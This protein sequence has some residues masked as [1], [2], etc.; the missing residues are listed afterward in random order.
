MEYICMFK[1]CFG[2]LAQEIQ[3]GRT[4]N[5]QKFPNIYEDPSD[6]VQPCF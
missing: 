4:H 1:Q 6:A 3:F 2:R 5:S